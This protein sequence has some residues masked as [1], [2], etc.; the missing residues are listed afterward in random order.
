[1]GEEG[2]PELHRYLEL[3]LTVADHIFG[4]HGEIGVFP[5]DHSPERTVLG[6][7]SEAEFVVDA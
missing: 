2:F 3:P 5:P 4:S 6:V 7:V 1:V